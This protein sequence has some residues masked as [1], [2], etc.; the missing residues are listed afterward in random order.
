MKPREIND[1]WWIEV[2]TK[3]LGRFFL[4]D[5]NYPELPIPIQFETEKEAFAHIQTLDLSKYEN[6]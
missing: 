4:L 1:K 3:S 2:N 6:L 5:K